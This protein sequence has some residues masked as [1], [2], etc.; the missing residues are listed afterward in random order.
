MKFKNR[1]V[2]LEEIRSEPYF[3]EICLDQKE[4][5]TRDFVGLFMSH[6]IKRIY[7]SGSGSPFNAGIVLKYAAEKLLN[8][9]ATCS[10][11]ML[12]NNHEGRMW[13]ENMVQRKWL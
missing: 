6:S 10:Y 1:N 13:E 2:M 3:F 4:K 7:F 9:E 8:I 12:F 11:P 5:I